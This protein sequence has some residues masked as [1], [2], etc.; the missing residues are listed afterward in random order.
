M[1]RSGN[2]GAT[3]PRLLPSLRYGSLINNQPITVIITM[4]KIY[5]IVCVLALALIVGFG[6]SAQA[7]SY[8]SGCSSTAGYSTT[9]GAS[10]NGATAIPAGCS[11][12]TGFSTT[13]GNPCNGQTLTA[14]GGTMVPLGC[15]TASGFS[16][17]TGASCGG[18][19]GPN[20]Y[21]GYYYP[22]GCS[23]TSGYSSISGMACNTVNSATVSTTAAGTYTYLPGCSSV[24]GYSSVT[25]LACSY[26]TFVAAN[27]N[28]TDPGI[29]NTG[30]GSSMPAAAVA[31]ALTALIAAFG[32]HRFIRSYKA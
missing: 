3:K 12:Y 30:A 20:A 18:V 31:I 14:N 4:K 27:P 2:F 15:S 16:A 5:S 13:T 10:C 11:S 21:G 22:A 9:S 7:Q 17:T 6:F 29:P 32:A 28:P 26:S 1:C 23:S 8:P 19:S 25:G 24:Y